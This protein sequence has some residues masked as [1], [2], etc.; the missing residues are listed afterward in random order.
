M[1]MCQ[2][3]PHTTYSSLSTS[4]RVWLVGMLEIVSLLVSYAIDVY[5]RYYSFCMNIM[6]EVFELYRNFGK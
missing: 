2:T 3:G 5:K 6:E 4:N 1:Y